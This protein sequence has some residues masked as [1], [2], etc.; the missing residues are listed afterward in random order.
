[1]TD[2]YE[3]DEKLNDD[4]SVLVIGAAGLDLIGRLIDPPQEGNYPSVKSLPANIRVSF[5]GVSRNVAENLARLGQPV[6]LLTAVGSDPTGNELLHL[7]ASFGVDVQPCMISEQNSTASY[8]AVLDP[9]G[10]RYFSL[11]DMAVLEEITPAYIQK[12]EACLASA[13][14]IFIDANLP[15]PTLEAV[16]QAAKKT[17]VLICADTTSVLLAPRLLPHLEQIYLLSANSSEASVLCQN[18]PVVTDR[19]SAL[20]A[21]RKLV[22][23]GAEL[24]IISLAEF[25]VVYATSETNGHV[26][27]I[28]TRI[29]DPTGAGDALTATVIFGI[30]NEIPIDESVQL[31][32]T[33]ASLILRYRGTVFPG[34]SLER[35]Y[36]ELVV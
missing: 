28:Q 33:A 29:L 8:L 24:V 35:L 12:N 34:L 30:L 14:V 4:C 36:D 22:N 7:T 20:I 21:A 15:A 3:S 27:A 9:Q 25:G 19:D 32:V 23:L 18:D 6:R 16:M 1:M 13:S 5:G 17:G 31:G 11:E 26:P 2:H 10:N